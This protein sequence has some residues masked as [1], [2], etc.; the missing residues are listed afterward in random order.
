MRKRALVLFALLTLDVQYIARH[1]WASR[2][3]EAGKISGPISLEPLFRHLGA[4]ECGVHQH[5]VW[6]GTPFSGRTPMCLAG[7][8]FFY[9]KKK[10]KCNPPNAKTMY[11]PSQYH[12][13]LLKE[14][15]P[16]GRIQI[17]TGAVHMRFNVCS[18][19][20]AFI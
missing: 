3:R 11:K 19:V 20:G 2:D 13:E 7:I 15:W 12:G 1:R 14:I 16:A 17:F 8:Q 18:P 6:Q 9:I 10:K 4:K 5:W